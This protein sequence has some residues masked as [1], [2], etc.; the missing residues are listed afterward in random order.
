[1]YT[2]PDQVT[3]G[4]ATSENTF[5]AWCKK[6]G[7]NML[8]NYSR[9]LLYDSSSRAK[10]AAFVKKAKDS[11]G[12]ILSTVDARFTSSKEQPGWIAYLDKYA[13]TVSEVE[14]LTEFE[15]YI[16]NDNG[17][18]DYAGWSNLLSTLGKICHDRNVKFNAYEGWIGNNY[19]G[20]EFSQVPVDEMVKWCDRIFIS[21]YVKESDYNSTNPGLGK[22]DN[23]MDKRCAAIAVAAP[24][25]GKVQEIVE[26]VS[27]ELKAWGAGND[28]LGNVFKSHS[29]YGSTYTGA[30]DAYN[31]ST[32]DILKNTD[33][34]GRTIFYSKYGQLARP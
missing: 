24:K 19:N 14:P 21:N 2:H 31:K 32:A 4:N 8:N 7:S 17:I 28:F 10:L 26:I 3:I 16:K 27:L 11:Y 33:L 9:S 23:R 22:W 25:Y 13:G 18:Y 34:V 5:L 30:V 20:Q 12:I 29:F 15:P 6:S 1:M